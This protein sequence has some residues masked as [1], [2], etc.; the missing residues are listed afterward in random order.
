MKRIALIDN[1]VV[2]HLGEARNKTQTEKEDIVRKAFEAL[3]IVGQMHE[4]VYKNEFQDRNNTQ[5]FFDHG[6]FSVLTMESIFDGNDAKKTYYC[7]LIPELYKIMSGTDLGLTDVLTQWKKYCSFGEV[8]CLAAC[9]VGKYGIFVS[10][11]HGSKNLNRLIETQY[12]RRI[13][14]YNREDLYQKLKPGTLNKSERKAFT[15]VR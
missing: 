8:H 3:G 14:V 9:L 7:Q 2:Q 4:L 1:D 5:Q 13:A 12:K 10:D 11:D 6:I 15:H